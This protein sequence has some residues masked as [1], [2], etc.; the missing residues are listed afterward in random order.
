MLSFT[1]GKWIWYSIIVCN[2]L[3]VS[4]PWFQY[5]FWIIEP[6]LF[7][8]FFSNMFMRY[9]KQLLIIYVPSNEMHLAEYSCSY[10]LNC[11]RLHEWITL[12]ERFA[13]PSGHWVNFSTQRNYISWLR[14]WKSFDNLSFPS[15][16]Q[17][18]KKT[19]LFVTNFDSSLLLSISCYGFDLLRESIATNCYFG[20]I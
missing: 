14:R 4:F 17:I 6:V 16:T 13:W 11:H 3:I 18:E 7:I 12:F 19:I 5:I 2:I 15:I 1:N 8:H 10:P 9:S 20:I